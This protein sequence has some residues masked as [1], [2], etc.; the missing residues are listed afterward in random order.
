MDDL[1]GLF[2]DLRQNKAGYLASIA[3]KDFEDRIDAKLHKMGYSRILRHD[4]DNVGGDCFN[5]IKCAVLERESNDKIGNIYTE[6][7]RHFIHQPFGRQNYPDFLVFSGE[8]IF[9]IE[10]KFSA[11][12][13]SKPVWNSGL[14]RPNGIYVFGSMERKDLT[15]FLGG[16]ILSIA[17]TRKLHDFFDK[18]LKEYQDRFNAETMNQQKYGFAAYIRKAFEQKKAFNKKAILNFFDNPERA[19]LESA[20]IE[21]LR[22]PQ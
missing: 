22:L 4:L 10:T 16:H 20:V 9:A 11:K 2:I 3:G 19:K 5:L 17:D 15:F 7:N 8:W 21:Y 14:P 6:F 13:Q 12:N 18:G 1:I